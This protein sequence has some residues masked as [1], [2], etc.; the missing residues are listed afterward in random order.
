MKKLTPL[1]LLLFAALSAFSQPQKRLDSLLEV[2]HKYPYQDSVKVIQL[3]GI[4]RQYVAMKD[5]GKGKPYADSAIAIAEKLPRKYSLQNTYVRMGT[6]YHGFSDYLQAVKYYNKALEAGRGLDAKRVDAGIYLNM[7]ALYMSVPDYA[8]S[9]EAHQNAV[10]LFSELNEIGSLGSCYMNIGSIYQDLNQ[11]K[12][13][14]EYVN[15]ALRIFESG[16]P[17]GRGVAVASDMLSKLYVQSSDADLSLLGIKPTE[18]LD[19]ALVLLNRTRRI[20]EKLED[21][22]LLGSSLSDIAQVYEEKGNK[23]EAL[24]YYLQSL[25]EYKRSDEVAGI[26]DGYISLG[27]YY[28]RLKN[29]PESLS[30]LHYGLQLARQTGATGYQRRAL[31]VLSEVHEKENRFDSSLFFYRQFI[32]MRD[33]IYNAE[34]ENEITRKQLQLDFGIKEREYQLTQQLMEGKMQQQLLLAKQQEQEIILRKQQLQISD[35]EKSL[36]RL[37]FLQTQADLENQ[38]S[39]QAIL[40]KQAQQKA[41]FDRLIKDKQ[42]AVQKVEINNNQILSAFLGAIALVV[43]GVAVFIFYSRR[44]TVK[45]NKLVSEQKLELEEL[46]SV[47]DKIFSVVSHDMRQPVNSLIS[48]TRILE[49]AEIPKEKL[50][51]YAAELKNN[52]S[53]TSALMEN[54]LNWAASQMHGFK[55]SL[56]TVDVS[57][58][59]TEVVNSLQAQLSQ[60]G[61]TLSNSINKGNLIKADRDMTAL[62]LRNVLSNAIKYSYT[63]GMIA[64]GVAHYG[65]TH[66]A[67]TIA[68][69]GTGISAEK[70]QLINAPAAHTIDSAYGTKKEKGTGLGLLLSKTFADMMGGRIVAESVVNQGSVFNIVLAKTA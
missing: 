17:E 57:D 27:S 30:K 61:V 28:S 8:K 12:L 42:I 52:L 6:A 69:Q 22:T 31:Q 67:V 15:K 63:G 47:K 51:L 21:Y 20:A 58:I 55:P 40:L 9:L 11:V 39:T 24:K 54:L 48:F 49:D 34:K 2:H 1:F 66:L 65:T 62:I 26:A 53:Y 5:F 43:F 13:A 3:R 29:Y 45:L 38:K 64:L 16:E 19:K 33:S 56:Q 68:D 60:K 70:V 23:Q 41:E 36:Q 32:V 46:V 14:S 4:F 25:A 18:K 59:A 44:K 37:T 7:G 10:Q 35:K 50:A